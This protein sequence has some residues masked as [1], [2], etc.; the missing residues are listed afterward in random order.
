MISDCLLKVLVQISAFVD[1]TLGGF[2]APREVGRW[3][4][5]G[6]SPMHLGAQIVKI[7]ETWL[8]REL[9]HSLILSW[10]LP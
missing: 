10:Y 6:G 1:S 8:D 5:W 7:V 9:Y 2:K 3:L 4:I